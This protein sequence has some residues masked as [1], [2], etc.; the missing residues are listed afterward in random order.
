MPLVETVHRASVD[1]DVKAEFKG[2]HNVGLSL[3]ANTN[4]GGNFNF[5]INAYAA[6][7]VIGIAVIFTHSFWS[8]VLL[9]GGLCLVLLSGYFLSKNSFGKQA[10]VALSQ[11]SDKLGYTEVAIE[12][13]C[14]ALERTNQHYNQIIASNT[15]DQELIKINEQVK[16]AFAIQ[17]ALE[18]NVL[19]LTENIVS[20]ARTLNDCLKV[21]FKKYTPGDLSEFIRER[22]V[23]KTILSK[24]QTTSKDYERQRKT[25]GNA[26]GNYLSRQ[27]VLADNVTDLEKH[28]SATEDA[29]AIATGVGV[30]TGIASVAAVVLTATAAPVALPIGL[31]AAAVSGVASI[32]S[33]IYTLA[34]HRKS[35]KTKLKKDET[36]QHASTAQNSAFKA[37]EIVESLKEVEDQ[38]GEHAD[39]M[40]VIANSLAKIDA[41][42]LEKINQL[43]YDLAEKKVDGFLSK[44]KQLRSRLKKIIYLTE[45]A[46]ASNSCYYKLRAAQLRQWIQKR[47]NSRQ[48]DMHEYPP[49]KIRNF[50]IIAHIDH[51]KSTLAD[52][53]LELSGT[54]QK[55]KENKQVLDN[56]KVEKER[57]ITVKAQTVSM[58]YK[59]KNE[60]YLL[61]L[62][63]T[64][65]LVKAS[66][67][68]STNS[69]QTI[70]NFYLAFGQD[71]KIIPV[72][73]KVDLPAADIEKTCDQIENTFE[74][75]TSEIRGISAKTGLGVDALFPDIIENIPA[76][77]GDTKAPFRALL[78]DTWYDKYAGVICLI[79][80]KDGVLKK[81][82]RIVSGYTKLNY[83]I[84]DLGIMY[85]QRASCEQLSAGQV[86]FVTMNLKSTREA[87]IGDTFYKQGQPTEL[88]EGFHPAQSMVFAG[89][90]PVDSSKHSDL[91]EAL[92]RL[93]LN[94]ASVSITKENSAALGQGFRL[95]FLGTLHMD[96]FRQ[97]LEE[98]YDTPVINTMPTVPYIIQYTNGEQVKIRNPSDFPENISTTSIQSFLEPMVN[99]TFVAPDKYLGKII[100][101]CN[102]HRGEQ[103]DCTYISDN[104]IMLKYRLPMAE[105]LTQFYDRL[106]SCTSGYASFDYEEAGYSEADLVKVNIMLNSKPVDALS[107]ITHRNNSE[108]VAKQWV[109]KLKNVIERQLFEIVIQ[110]SAGG[111]ICARE[112]IKAAR[113]DVTAKCYGG[114]ITR[115][116]KLL[117]K[118][119][120]NK[121][122][123]KRVAG[124]LYKDKKIKNYI[125]GYIKQSKNKIELF[126]QD[127]NHIDQ[128]YRNVEL[129]EGLEFDLEKYHVEMVSSPVLY[130]SVKANI[131]YRRPTL[132]PVVKKVK[133]EEEIA[134]TL[135][136][137]EKPS[138]V[139]KVSLSDFLHSKTA[140]EKKVVDQSLL[141]TNGNNSNMNVS[142]D[143]DPSNVKI[144]RNDL[145]TKISHGDCSFKTTHSNT[146]DQEDDD[147]VDQLL[148]THSVLPPKTIIQSDDVV[149]AKPRASLW[150]D[151][152]DHESD[153]ELDNDPKL[154]AA[155][156]LAIEQNCDS[157]IGSK[158]DVDLNDLI[159]M[160]DTEE[161]SAQQ[162][163]DLFK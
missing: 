55:T 134:E 18:R 142:K 93:T 22:D 127:K 15:S 13:L 77:I 125:D 112:T 40:E 135:V 123:M 11:V 101:L 10:E 114:D 111:K 66:K 50:S 104:R 119:K 151:Y 132:K 84:S 63:D 105:I 109:H 38:W 32:G 54:I 129:R 27:R 124:G 67:V 43:A 52:R 138:G 59:Y 2:T 72:I 75:D 14:L 41:S 82:D 120:E 162:L 26:A 33:A 62:I 47:F 85:P 158:E 69:A 5:S 107:C 137:K 76:P 23:S 30:G 31:G 144:Y 89:L 118:Q 57:G 106:K 143:L 161:M 141:Y 88:F 61:N 80:I 83:E 152:N 78:F 97:R 46:I 126:D 147:L 145:P 56:L 64:P 99:G 130:D 58:F 34:M 6:L 86:G 133:L 92:D 121:K 139:K 51:G 108:A 110:G 9:I 163:L 159:E 146:F 96:V 8:K 19:S 28:L 90:F 37:G 136:E 116:M 115:K 20:H 25:M 45:F 60:K 98:E 154:N 103:L 87:S 70:A 42:S 16:K 68:Y 48:I 128:I 100:E 1:G 131:P 65:M 155:E 71:L 94:D 44:M 150:N 53:L 24:I 29:K 91:Q 157:K 35:E 149:T 160:S 117:D 17:Q 3:K 153:E 148:S 36:Q 49:D 74:L 122:K 4:I 73:N 95:G 113:K 39:D 12:K 156:H 21:D 81:G 140:A 79:A 102:S 7:A